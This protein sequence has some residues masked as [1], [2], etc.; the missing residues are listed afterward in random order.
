M[1]RGG[2][3]TNAPEGLPPWRKGTHGKWLIDNDGQFHSW[4]TAANLAPHHA[5]A[6]EH[7]GIS[8]WPL[9]G[10]VNPDGSLEPTARAPGVDATRLLGQVRAQAEA[11][12]MKLAP[13]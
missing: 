1:A 7:L 8:S 2:R 5:I 9:D 3:E 4:R 11:L 12:G 13:R 10:I 6:A